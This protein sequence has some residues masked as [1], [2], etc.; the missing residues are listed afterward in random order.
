MKYRIFILIFFLLCVIPAAGMLLV[1]PAQP[2]ANET[3]PQPPALHTPEG[4]FNKNLLDEFSSYFEERFAFRQEMI[5][6]SRTLSAAVFRT[7]TE[8]KVILGK[9]GW[10]FYGETLDDYERVNP[11]TDREIWSAAHSLALFQEA[12]EAQGVNFL[13]TAAPNKNTLYGEYMPDRY[14]VADRETDLSRLTAALAEEGVPYADLLTPLLDQEEILYRKQDSHWTQK[15]AALAGDTILAAL[16]RESPAFFAGPFEEVWQA[17]GDLY[18]ML[19]PAGKELDRDEVY[20]WDFTFTYTTPIRSV[21]DTQIRT[22]C[23]G[24]SGRLVMFRDSFGNAL[25]PFLAESF[26]T[27]CFSRVTPYDITCIQQEQA[28][29]VVIELVQRNLDWLITRP[30]IF[31]APERDLDWGAACPASLDLT[32]TAEACGSLPGFLTVQGSWSG[33][34]TDTTSP[35]YLR[36]GETVY[37]LTPTGENLFSGCVPEWVEGTACRLLFF[38]EGRLTES[39]E[40]IIE[41]GELP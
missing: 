27:A 16:N 35:L 28:D 19:F 21:E 29:T 20:A 24:K 39:N 26:E 37:E 32:L 14:P 3:L 33:G 40:F 13:F 15:G 4:S 11:M 7:S 9:E 34:C 25:Y 12:C 6:A 38:A 36:S 23:A 17:K 2:A 10:L 18:E 5:T 30:A 8:E 22:A 31:P 1:G 41:K